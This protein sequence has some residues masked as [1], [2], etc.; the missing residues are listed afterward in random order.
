MGNANKKMISR[1]VAS[2]LIGSTI[3]WYDFFFYA[4]VAGIVFNRFYFPSRYPFICLML[5]FG[6]FSAG[7]VE[8][9]YGGVIYGQFGDKIGRISI[10]VISLTIMGISTAF[11][12]FLPSYE[13]IGVFATILSLVL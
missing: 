4:V 13:Q 10:R 9:P 11:V 3:E 5:V 1:V 12:S 8:R 2:S 7:F 6:T